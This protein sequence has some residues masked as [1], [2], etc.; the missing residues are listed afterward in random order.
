MSFGIAIKTSGS[1]AILFLLNNVPV[2]DQWTGFRL[3]IQALIEA[4]IVQ[5]II[6][7]TD[8]QEVQDNETDEFAQALT[9]LAQHNGYL[10]LRNP[11]KER[12]QH[13]QAL[14]MADHFP[15]IFT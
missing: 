7:L 5:V 3:H 1:S 4:G 14:G 10:S 11:G 6:D 13:L 8:C 12:L 15:L 9:L 2:P